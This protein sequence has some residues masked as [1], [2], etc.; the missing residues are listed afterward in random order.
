MSQD[1]GYVDA[2]Y[3]QTAAEL[4]APIK[5]RS[6]ALMHIQPG[7]RLLDVGCGPGI[8]TV[9]LA[10]HFEQVIGLDPDAEMLA[11][12]ARRAAEAGIEK[13]S[14]TAFALVILTYNLKFLWAWV[15][16]GVKL[17]LLTINRSNTAV[18]FTRTP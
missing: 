1:R 10:G 18:L 8:L 15:V 17:P 11:E 9:E 13:K 4:L 16:E 7:Q 2:S 6:Y 14:V 5:Q 12:G 3:L